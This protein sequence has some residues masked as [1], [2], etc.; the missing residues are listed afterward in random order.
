MFNQESQQIVVFV[1]SISFLILLLAGLIAFMIFRYQNKQLIYSKALSDLQTI[2]E[3]SILQAQLEIQE[4]TFAH[5]SREIHDNIGQKLTLAKL[6]LNTLEPAGQNRQ[7]RVIDDTV[8]IIGEVIADLSDLSRTMG[9][10]IIQQCGLI[11]AIEYEIGLL[12]KAGIYQLKLTITGEPVF[13]DANKE[14]VLFRIVQESLNNIVK[15]A[16]AVNIHIMLHYLPDELRLRVSDDGKGFDS[17]ASLERGNGLQNMTRRAQLLQG[18]CIVES[19]A[20]KG[21]SIL[22]KIPLTNESTENNSRHTGR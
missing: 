9:S 6:Y 7:E 22:I 2:H 5:I 21:T 4:Q 18:S 8:Q 12:N 14:L 11:K 3:K 17:S 20:G 1:I 19:A 10:E 15:H 13:L 16:D